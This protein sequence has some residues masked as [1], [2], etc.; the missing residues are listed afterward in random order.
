[1]SW[2]EADLTTLA[3]CWRLDRRDGITIGLTSHDRDLWFA[4]LLHRA[5]PGMVPSAIETHRTMAAASVDLQGAISSS[6]L[7]EADLTAGLWDGARLSLHA[8]NW[9]RPDVVP[10]FLVRG[11]LGRIETA[12]NG[13]SVELTGPLAALDRPVTE[14]TTP[15]CRAT[16]GDARCRVDLRAR[17]VLARVASAAGHEITLDQTFADHRF[18]LGQVRWLSGQMAGQGGAILGQ[19]GDRLLLADPV[20]ASVAG[21]V[22]ALTE[23]CDRTLATCAGR[24][25][26]AINFQGEP[27]LPGNDLLTRY[28][29]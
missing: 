9:A 22:I 25:A 19:T 3:F 10:V 29:G 2:F 6:L 24:F 8:V 7:T 4:D 18:A 27:H 11:Q 14:V 17:R 13:F 15:H 5:A 1:M 28:G 26:N 20:S 12:G 23:G 21:A 16:L